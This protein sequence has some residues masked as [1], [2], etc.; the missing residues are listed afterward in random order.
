MR[1]YEFDTGILP[2]F[3]ADETQQDYYTSYLPSP[4]AIP[5]FVEE[6]EISAL[7][8][9]AMAAEGFKSIVPVTYEQVIK[10]KLA[11]DFETGEMLDLMLKNVRGDTMFAYGNS[12]YIFNLMFYLNDDRA[13]FSSYW[14][15]K[16]SEVTSDMNKLLKK[17]QKLAEKAD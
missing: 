7:V 10:R 14:A 17:Y 11:D 4:F 8:M 3:K 5:S 13:Q 2:I 1:N 15:S 6:P 9:T 16:K 12:R